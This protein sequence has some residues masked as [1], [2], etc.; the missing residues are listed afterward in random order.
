MRTVLLD[1]GPMAHLGG[2]GSLSGP[3]ATDY[4][5]LTYPAGKGI[6]VNDGIIEKIGE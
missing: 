5:S 2:K 6:V 4:D 3:S 1:I